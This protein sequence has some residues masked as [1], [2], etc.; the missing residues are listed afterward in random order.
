MYLYE[1]RRFRT[2]INKK[3]SEINRI[4]LYKKKYAHLQF[5]APREIGRF[6]VMTM[7]EYQHIENI[8]GFY[9]YVTN[10][11]IDDDTLFDSV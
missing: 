4:N 2:F 11:W 3:S 6:S 1:I 9:D 8:E 10:T 5:M 7:D